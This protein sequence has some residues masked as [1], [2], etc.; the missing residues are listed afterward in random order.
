[1]LAIAYVFGGSFFTIFGSGELQSWN[2]PPEQNGTNEIEEGVPLKSGNKP[3][4][5]SS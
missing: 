5:T 4:I 2:S 1:M 3:A